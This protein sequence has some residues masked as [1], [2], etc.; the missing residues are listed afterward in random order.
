MKEHID[1]GH[2]CERCGNFYDH[3]GDIHQ[4][5]DS[6]SM[7]VLRIL[8]KNLYSKICYKCVRDQKIESILDDVSS[9]VPLL[10]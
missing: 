5:D 9:R 8:L 7:E 10:K 2:Y 4:E 1:I 3:K 6:K